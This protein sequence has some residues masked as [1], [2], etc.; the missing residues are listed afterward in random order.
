VIK[1]DFFFLEE[2]KYDIVPEGSYRTETYGIGLFR[3]AGLKLKT[4]LFTHRVESPAIVTMGPFVIRGWEK[5][6]ENVFFQFAFFT[7]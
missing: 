6:D 3:K 1:S 7:E 2:D 5:S 4:D